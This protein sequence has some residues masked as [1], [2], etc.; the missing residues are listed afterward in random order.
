MVLVIITPPLEGKFFADEQS[1]K[2][3]YFYCDK[4]IYSNLLSLV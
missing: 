3:E 2:T 4:N 1:F